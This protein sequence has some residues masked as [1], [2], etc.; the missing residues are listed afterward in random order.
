MLLQMLLLW[1]RHT[2]YTLNI[3]FENESSDSEAGQGLVEY[4]LLMVFVAVL[5]MVLLMLLGPTVRNMFENVV[6]AMGGDPS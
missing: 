2:L 6:R 4:A 1:L 3:Q 5:V